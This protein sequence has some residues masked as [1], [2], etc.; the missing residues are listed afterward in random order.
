MIIMQR[1]ANK[2]T[3]RIVVTSLMAALVFVGNMISFPIPD[4]MGVTRIHLGNS[5]CLLAG[6]LFGG[7]SGG[8]ASGIGGALYDVINP[9]YIVS[10]PYTF[11]SKFA[12]GFTCGLINKHKPDEKS[13]LA[14]TIIAAVSGQLVYI[15]LYLGKKFIEGLVAGGTFFTAIGNLATSALSSTINATLS[16]IIAVPLY[17]ALKK[18]LSKTPISAVIS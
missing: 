13:H 16:V 14:R 17:Y 6:L 1:T 5:M 3:I 12:M 18:A 10:A 11:F 2:T 9:V 7:V 8:V 15:V 4:L